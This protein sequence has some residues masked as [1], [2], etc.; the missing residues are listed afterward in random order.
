MPKI[1]QAQVD[2]IAA[3]LANSLPALPPDLIHALAHGESIECPACQSTTKVYRRPL[4]SARIKAMI[5]LDV[6]GPL[7]GRALGEVTGSLN[8]PT[9]SYFGLISQ[10]NSTWVLTDKG[11]DFLRGLISVHSHVL[12]FQGVPVAFNGDTVTAQSVVRFEIGDG[13]SEFDAFTSGTPDPRP[14]QR[15]AIDDILDHQRAA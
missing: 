2:Y 14:T 10:L 6:R 8:Y 12:V 5:A 3:H 11:R 7:S 13:L 9:A 1:T 4:S 15:D